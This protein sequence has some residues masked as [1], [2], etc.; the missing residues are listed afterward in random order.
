M[1]PLKWGF[2]KGEEEKAVHSVYIKPKLLWI[3][4]LVSFYFL[5]YL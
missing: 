3:F 2:W 5:S 1:F 4:L